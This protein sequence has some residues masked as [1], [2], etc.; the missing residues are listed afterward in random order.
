MKF[1]KEKLEAF[2]RQRAEARLFFD[3]PYVDPIQEDKLVIAAADWLV[4]IVGS[5][6]H[7]DDM[8]IENQSAPSFV[9]ELAASGLKTVVLNFDPCFNTKNIDDTNTDLFII[10][11]PEALYFKPPDS[12]LPLVYRAA[13]EKQ[14][15]NF[16]A[17][18][19]VCNHFL[20]QGE[21]KKLILIDRIH[22]IN[23]SHLMIYRELERQQQATLI[24]SYF[25]RFPAVIYKDNIELLNSDSQSVGIFSFNPCEHLSMEEYKL[26]FEQERIS[27]Q[28]PEG[29]RAFSSM[30]EIKIGCLGAVKLDKDLDASISNFMR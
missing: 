21:H 27:V 11:Y 28:L 8:L 26:S 4:V 18:V 25:T 13:H 14:W 17:V 6:Q 20:S 2:R 29:W 9:F 24:G 1:T 19:S 5:H 15:K 7:T 16:K 22:P 30:N 10:K 12:T 23:N 3:A